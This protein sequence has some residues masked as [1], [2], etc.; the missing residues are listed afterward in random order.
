MI[1]KVENQLQFTL[2]ISIFS[3]SDLYFE[4]IKYLIQDLIRLKFQILLTL[5]QI[6]VQFS[7]VQSLRR[8]RLF[9]T[10]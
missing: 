2:I 3:N 7:S 5:L 4:K 10:P 1:I 6:S 8:V 9:A